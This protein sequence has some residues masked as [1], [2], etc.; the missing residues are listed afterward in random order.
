MTGKS[1]LTT[2]KMVTIL[3]IREF[4][5]PFFSLAFPVGLVLIFGG[6]FG[7]EPDPMLGGGA[8]WT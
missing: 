8:P 4:A 1:F 6:I 2:I 3:Y 7:N 5:S